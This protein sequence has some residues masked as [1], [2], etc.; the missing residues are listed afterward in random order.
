MIIILRS[1]R[2]RQYAID[3]ILK[4]NAEK[5]WEVVIRP[6]RKPRT[7]GQN[8]LIHGWFAVIARETGNDPDDVKE[9]LKIKFLPRRYVEIDGETVEVRR[10]TAK[11]TTGEMTEF[12]DRLQAWAASELAITLPT[13]D[14]MREVA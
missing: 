1:E 13:R 12:C 6:Y 3:S 10:S 2:Q 14:D 11:L 4:L 8:A 5:P 9:A 7:L